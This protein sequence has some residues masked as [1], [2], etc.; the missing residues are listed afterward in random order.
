[1]RYAEFINQSGDKLYVSIPTSFRGEGF[2]KQW[3]KIL[4]ESLAYRIFEFQNGKVVYG[5]DRNEDQYQYT[6]DERIMIKL[7]AIPIA[8]VDYK[9]MERFIKS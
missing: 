5:K 1:M 7:M 6:E 4:I 9:G 3:S 8:E 2:P